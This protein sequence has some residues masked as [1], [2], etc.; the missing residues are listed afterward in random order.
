MQF[1]LDAQAPDLALYLPAALQLQNHAAIPISLRTTGTVTP[2]DWHLKTLQLDS[3][4][5]VISGNGL[6]ERDGDEFIDSHLDA[7]IKIANLSPF[8]SWL[9]RPLP[10]QDLQL[11]VE[12]DSRAGVL[13]VEQLKMRSG[14]SDL[15][16]T[17]RAANPSFPELTL[18]GQ[19]QLCLL[20]T[21]DAADE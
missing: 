1:D 10:D 7:E 19:S 21:S 2:D 13:L 20:Y 14:D 17:G 18:A 12:L 16:V 3:I 9:A 5:A 11:S 4:Q 8:S 6:L 15:S